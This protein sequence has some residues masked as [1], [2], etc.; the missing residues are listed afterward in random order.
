[1]R[2]FRDM[3]PTPIGVIG[4][5]VVAATV[6]AALQYDS[7]PFVGAQPLY[8]AVFTETAGLAEGN[9]VEVAGVKV[10]EVTSLEFD[11]PTVVVAFT[12]DESIRLG[13]AS[14][15]DIATETVLGTKGLRVRP[16]GDG[17]LDR[18]TIALEQTSAPYELTDALG[19]LTT[20][21][22]DVDT[23]RLGDSLQTVSETLR[24]VPEDLR[25]AL[26]GVS[27]L[28]ATVGSRDR[29]L[30]ALLSNAEQVTGLLAE[31]S[32][33]INALILDGNELLGELVARR[34]AIA[35]LSGHVSAVSR[36]IT[37]VIRDNEAQLAPTLGRLTSV[38]SVLQENSAALGLA[39]DR[40]GPYVTQLGEAVASGPFFNSY[41]QNLIPA[42][43]MR[44]FVDAALASRGIR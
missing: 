26:D 4:T 14:T 32:G 23:D 8:R 44:P 40:L 24:E 36:A 41:I 9:R 22:R 27:R 38:L 17:E 31:R 10:G 12:L 15:A 34:D 28:S 35:E 13:R 20:K 6:A 16:I 37:A 18:R 25:A 43:I 2:R 7:L 5:A 39:I 42:E 1:M 33:Q 19:D 3:N 30:R 29:D 21:V 11:G